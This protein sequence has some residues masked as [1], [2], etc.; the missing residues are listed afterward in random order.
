[1]DI[2]GLETVGCRTKFP[3]RVVLASFKPNVSEFKA[4]A[5]L[6]TI[7]N[8]APSIVPSAVAINSKPGAV[9]TCILPTVF[10]TGVIEVIVLNNP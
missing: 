1:M 4:L 5:V 9:P 8:C 3:K 10:E 6:D 7:L 2:A